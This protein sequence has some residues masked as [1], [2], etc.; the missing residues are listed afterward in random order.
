MTTVNRTGEE[1]AEDLLHSV[2]S[3]GFRAATRLLGAHR[4]GWWLRRL[5][6]EEAGLSQAAGQPVINRE[7]S[8]PWVDWDAL[9]LLLLDSPWALKASASEMA[10]LE[11]ATSLAGAHRVQLRKAVDVVSAG[12]L[13]LIL[14]AMEEAAY[15]EVR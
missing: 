4:D 9:G 15:G 7:S 10:M 8:R 12:E 11:V 2:G 6:A 13:R 3:E 5:L 1:L 14:R